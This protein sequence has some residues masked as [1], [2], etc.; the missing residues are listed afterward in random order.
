[1]IGRDVFKL[2]IL[3]TIKLCCKIEHAL[4][5]ILHLEIWLCLLL[6]KSIFCHT[7]L[8]CIVCPVPRLDLGACR[9][10]TG[11]DVLIHYSLHISNL[12]LSLHYRWSDDARQERIHSLGSSGHLVMKDHLCRI[13]ISKKISLLHAKSHHLQDK[14]L[15]IILVTIVS[16]RSI[17]L[18]HFLAKITVSSRSHC[19][20]IL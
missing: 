6:I 20:S 19:S 8:L 9:K 16:T 1:M 11:L 12:L 7:H 2:L 10:K 18:E 5:D 17:C 4:T 13:L 15:C 14:I 3:K